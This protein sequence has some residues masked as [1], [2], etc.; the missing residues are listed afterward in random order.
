MLCREIWNTWRTGGQHRST[1][2]ATWKH[3][4][5]SSC[6]HVLVWFTV[7]I[8]HIS[9]IFHI[10]FG[11]LRGVSRCLQTL[12]RKAGFR[13]HTGRIW[14]NWR[15]R[16]PISKRWR[17]STIKHP[18]SGHF[19]TKHHKAPSTLVA[20]VLC[21]CTAGRPVCPGSFGVWLSRR[22]TESYEYLPS[23][24]H[25]KFSWRTKAERSER[26]TKTKIETYWNILK[27]IET[28]WNIL[29]HIEIYWNILK[30][31][32]TYWNIL[33]HIETYWNILK[34]IETYWNILK[35]IET[36]WNILKHIETYWN[37]LKHIEIYWNILKYIETYWN[38]L[39]HIETYWNIL[40]H[41][42]TY[43]NILKHIEIYWNILKYIET[44]WNILKHI[45]TY[46]NIL[47]Y[48]ETY[49]NILKH[50]EIYWN[51]LKHI[52][53]YWNILKHI[54]T[55]W[56]IL[57]HIEIYWNIWKTMG[58]PWEGKLQVLEHNV[59]GPGGPRRGS[60][61]NR[62]RG[63]F[64]TQQIQSENV[65]NV[66]NVRYLCNITSWCFLFRLDKEDTNDE[67]DA[68]LQY[69]AIPMRERMPPRM[70]PW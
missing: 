66:R 22:M 37:I 15:T 70:P 48:I 53:T 38:I 33:K 10:S 36:Y 56:N 45:E 65:R 54:E 42:E 12:Y 17:Q 46:W 16:F 60:G 49:W 41:I 52:E 6:F 62:V 40:K 27:H 8:C 31:I 32:E 64:K 5:V 69:I 28:Y 57:K 26:M 18:A 67:E 44:Y 58:I 29:K 25:S 4:H 20:L 24:D 68:M 63:L 55:Y 13:T 61:V 51:I 34:Y 35:H 7:T 39:K 23:Q 43:W 30:Y 9:T 2:L 14:P 1:Q 3:G 50:I 21:P 47:K 11:R 19:W 59:I